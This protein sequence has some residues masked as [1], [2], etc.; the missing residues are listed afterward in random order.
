VR[1]G[2]PVAASPRLVQDGGMPAR[3]PL[4]L[5]LRYLRPRRSFLSVITLISVLG[6][7][8]GVL[9][10]VVVRAV[11]LGFEADFRATLMGAEPHVLLAAGDKTPAGPDWQAVLER[12]RRESGTVSAAPYA[13]GMLYLAAGDRQT[14]AQTF[15][16]EIAAA[17]P[18]LAKLAR[19]LLDG[20]LDLKPGTVVLPDYQAAELGVG[21]GDEISV[22]AGN[23][24]N[25][26]VR[27]YSRANEEADA[28]RRRAILE[29]I[30]LNPQ[31]LVVAG[32][33]R[34][35]TGGY[36]AYV[37]LDTGRR[38]FSLGDGA[39][40]GLAVELTRPEAAEDYR[41]RLQP[42]LP[43]WEFT[44]WTDAGEARLAAMHNEQ[45]MMQ[46]VLSIIA[47]VAAF[48]VMNTTITV[49]T[50]KRREIGVLAALGCRRGQILGIFLNQAGV[51]GLLG[52]GL[53]LGGSLLV[54]WLR[55]D[56]R[57]LLAV[58]TGGQVHAVEGVFLSTIPALVRPWDVALTCLTSFGLCLLAG[59]IP[60]WFAARVDPAVALRD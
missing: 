39:V 6:V 12:V 17:Q 1:G 57:A 49:T 9:M 14:G 5:A 29:A 13:G 23:N 30:R 19:H 10:M 18:V 51:V 24:V 52:T 22:Y 31:P 41:D 44:L 32:I 11:M 4:F 42:Q 2:I 53:G 38:L 7:A 43:G 15:G 8:V 50:Q 27:D 36:N 47:L 58:V 33:L 55:D 56:L 46:F 16:L 34:S 48:S 40:T 20:D 59:L 25:A 3:A 45:V 37:D 35:E 21:V 28:A 26:A 60:A 54:L